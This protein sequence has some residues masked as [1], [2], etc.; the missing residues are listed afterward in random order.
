MNDIFTKEVSS[1]LLIAALCWIGGLLTKWMQSK[2]REMTTLRKYE[3]LRAK[4]EVIS[5]L[6]AL[7]ISNEADSKLIERHASL[8]SRELSDVLQELEADSFHAA[9]SSGSDEDAA[10][11]VPRVFRFSRIWKPFILPPSYGFYSWLTKLIYYVSNFILLVVTMSSL[12]YVVSVSGKFLDI[13]PMGFFTSLFVV[14]SLFWWKIAVFIH[15]K[16]KVDTPP[17]LP[18]H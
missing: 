8:V 4:V 5:R 7:S 2:S 10:A 18:N 17:P 1:G 9:P 16:S 14:N 6:S 11:P 3:R 15:K 13:I 12:S